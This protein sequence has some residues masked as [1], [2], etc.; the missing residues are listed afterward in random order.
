MKSNILTIIKKEL[1]RF[2]G[3]RGL[4]IT[5]VLLPGVMIY[6]IYSF[7]GSALTGM[8]T[9]DEDYRYTVKAVNMPASVSALLEQSGMAL[10]IS[11]IGEAEAD[12]AALAV[13]EKELDLLAVFPPDF[14]NAVAS[15]DISSGAPAPQVSLYY[16]STR[17]ESSAVQS[18]FVAEL[19]GYES[20]L[21]NKFDIA[22]DRGVDLAT[23][24][25]ATGFMFSSMM[26]MLL[27]IFLFSGCMSLAPEAIAGEKERGTMATMLVT[28]LKRGELAVGKIVSLSLIALMSGASSTV[29]TLLAMPKLMGGAAESMSAA[30]YGAGDYAL[31]AAV[32]LSTVLLLVAVIS[33]ISAFT[34]T[35]KEAQSAVMPLMILV[36]L[37]GVT[38]MFGG[39]A[40][41]N[42]AYYLIPIYNSVQSMAAIFSFETVAVNM[43]IT[44]GVN[45]I[46]SVV[47]GWALTRMFNSERV[48][49][50]R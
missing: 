25:D 36:M 14:D 32:I 11:D 43:L 13:T 40:Q 19:D 35:V 41:T 31:L 34:K 47:C 8:F 7:M 45:V 44:V 37:V 49:F 30:Y 48:M 50:R 12:A 1:H 17:T 4:F 21:A 28:P 9:P 39:G 20:T 2:F 38:A 22:E 6:V 10:D 27:M 26:P 16:N 5:T 18:M 15:Y 42:T 29:G 3:D 24:K 23:E 33:I 46:L